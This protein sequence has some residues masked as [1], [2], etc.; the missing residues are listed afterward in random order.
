MAWFWLTQTL[1]YYFF[2]LSL[3]THIIFIRVFLANALGFIVWKMFLP[4]RSRFSDLILDRFVVISGI[5][6]ERTELFQT[7]LLRVQRKF[8][9]SAHWLLAPN[10]VGRSL[11]QGQ[12]SFL[13]HFAW[14]NIINLISKV[15]LPSSS[16]SFIKFCLADD[17]ISLLRSL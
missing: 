6:Q 17:L 7:Q 11:K 1:S 9:N 4:D 10:I 12:Y 14:M 8:M 16:L 3:H 13:L 15:E 2:C 5:L